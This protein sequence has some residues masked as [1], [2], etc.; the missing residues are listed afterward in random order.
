MSSNS[1]AEQLQ[2][3]SVAT[4]LFVDD[5]ANILSALKRLFR[6]LGYRIITAQSGREGLEL[7]QQQTVDLV[8][9]DMRMP[10]MDGAAFLEQVVAHWPDTVRILLTGYA[11]LTS[12]IKAVNSG[13]IYRY[14]SK[15]WE[16]ND[17]TL[18]VK[19]AL[20]QKNLEADRDRLQALTRKQNEELKQLNASLEDKV[21]ARTGELQ[22]TVSFLELAQESLDSS[23]QTTVELFSNLIEMREHRAGHARQVAEQAVQLGQLCGLDAADLRNL[24]NAAL[25]RNVG[26]VGLADSLLKKPLSTMND[27]E[28]KTFTRHPIIGEG[29]LMALEPLHDAA[30]L[31]RHQHEQIDGKGYPDHLKG[32]A[33]PL[34]AQIL[35]VV[36]DYHDLQHGLV[37]SVHLD[38]TGARDYL[39]EQRGSRYDPRALDMF[40]KLLGRQAEQVNTVSERC[41]KSNGLQTGM[42]LSRDL[43]LGDKVLLLSKGYPL[44]D[45]LIERIHHLEESIDDDLDIYIIND[46]VNQ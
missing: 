30:R 45:S 4:L 46:G 2:S 40:R 21:R 12:T 41:V 8:I 7:L 6:P 20:E 31:I 18:S 32:E 29:V 10:E 39:I 35:K 26:K 11:D 24:R 36:G 17:I 27:A 38:A 15:P 25:L 5:E 23:Y 33:I 34:A 22:Q 19:R 28:H 1:N 14:I 42:V 43:V 9:S 3:N 44:N 13:Q 37:L 16:E